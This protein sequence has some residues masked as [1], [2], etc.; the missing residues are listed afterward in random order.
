MIVV[1]LKAQAIA[2]RE[3]LKKQVTM[4]D[5]LGL[6]TSNSLTTFIYR[7]EQKIEVSLVSWTRD[8]LRSL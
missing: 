6:T 1:I 2:C 3:I 7:P 4:R 8:I 5:A